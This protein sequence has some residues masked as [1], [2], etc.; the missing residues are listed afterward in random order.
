[1]VNF[2]ETSLRNV[3]KEAFGKV[4]EHNSLVSYSFLLLNLNVI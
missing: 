2:Y 1:M 4:P 3:I